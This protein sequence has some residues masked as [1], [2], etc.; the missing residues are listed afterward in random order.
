M[1]SNTTGPPVPAGAIMAITGGA[2]GLGKAAAQAWIAG[3][4]RV[5]IMDI[6][7]DHINQTVQQLGSRARGVVTDV[8]SRQSVDDAFETISQIEGQLDALV[9]CAGNALPVESAKMTD[10]QFDSLLQVHLNGT[11][12]CTR[13][14]YP[15][16]KVSR[17]TIVTVSSVAGSH[18]MPRRASYNTV[19]HG[20]IGLTKSLAVEWAVDGIRTNAI[21]PGYTQTPFNQQLV[22]EGKLDMAPTVARIPMQR[23][24]EPK[25]MAEPIVFLSTA[26]SSFVNGHTLVVDGGMTIAGDWY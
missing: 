20:I 25:E 11:M 9:C 12:R 8:T 3:G 10:E 2:S 24:A 19:K 21:A 18:G 13:A 5:I 16:L 1:T 4:G 22:D 26:A 23:W 17:G 15:L 14:A 7:E 6:R